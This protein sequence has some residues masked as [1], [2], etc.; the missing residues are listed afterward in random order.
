MSKVVNRQITTEWSWYLL[1]REL[2]AHRA[3]MLIWYAVIRQA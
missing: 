2:I 3:L 1:A